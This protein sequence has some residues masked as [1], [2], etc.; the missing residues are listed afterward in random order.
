MASGED[1]IE[2][3]R[4]N[5]EPIVADAEL[6]LVDLQF[7]QESVGWVLRLIL[8][9]EGGPS[10][11]DCARVSR[12]VS[13]LFDVEDFIPYRYTL[14]VSS[15]GLDRPLRTERDFARNVGKKVKLTWRNDQD[16]R[17]RDFGMILRARDGV[18]VLDTGKGESSFDL[19]MIDKGMLV[20][21]IGKN[22]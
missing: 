12:E 15:P 14:E 20:V 3:I 2:K 11:D 13:Y 7:R 8:H 6:E 5:V 9:R 22:K 1:L 4:Q 10:I 16:E 19:T 17:Q 21:E 18:V